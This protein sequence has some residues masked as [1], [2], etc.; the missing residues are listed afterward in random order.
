MCGIAGFWSRENSASRVDARL[1]IASMRD[2]LRHRGPDDSG[3][4][5]DA[6][7][8]I[9]LGHTRLSIVDLSPNGHQ[10]MHSRCGRFCIVYNGEVYNHAALRQQ[11][12]KCGHVFRGHSDTEVLLAGIVE[13]GLR[14]TVERCI[15][16]FAFA[17]W[18]QHEQQLTLVRDRLGIKPLYYGH[19]G[20]TLFFA[21]ELKALRAHPE[22]QGEIDRN[23][24]ALYLR[25]NYVP[26]PYSI[27]RGIFKLPPGTLLTAGVNRALDTPPVAWWSAR[28]VVERGQKTPFAGSF[29]DAV[30]ELDALL[31]DAVRLRMLSDVPLGAFL[32]GGIDSSLIVALMQKQSD[33][34]VQTFTIGFDDPQYN[35]APFAMGVARHLHTDHC[36]LYVSARQARD[37]IPRLPALYDEPFGDSSQIPTF[38]VS[39]LARRA[40][41]V[42]LS[43]DGG[44][45]LFG[46]YNR[47]FHIGNIWRRMSAVPYPLRRGAA[48][49]LRA[50]AACLPG[51]RR[52]RG[53]HARLVHRA[54]LLAIPDAGHLYGLV[55]THWPPSQEIV[56]GGAPARAPDFE[57]AAWPPLPSDFEQWMY[58]DL[59][60]YLPSDILVKVDRASMAVGLEAR[61]PL[62]D[63]RVVEFAWTLP[64][65][66]KVRGGQ[67]KRILRELL[68]RYVPSELFERPKVGFGV[69]IDAWLRGPLRDWAETLLSP[70]RLESEG[71]FHAAPIRQKWAEHLSG[72]RNWQYH[73]W[74]VLMFQSWFEACTARSEGRLNGG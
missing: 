71:F 30:N 38:L 72:R 46:G 32:S 50:I 24:L 43:G 51:S 64:H 55:N 25:H 45:E 74:D 3:Q 58:A 40:V 48:G 53:L 47:Y 67:G 31:S 63:H 23:V 66:F 42:S 41:T 37:V 39:E 56:Q 13:W 69:P 15:G 52:N 61:V 18:D 1:V 73:L 70:E 36:E 35:E 60:T 29:N 20:G 14:P 5:L 10:P 8:G 65:A 49:T 12:Q 33:R 27:Y 2:R 16:M 9:A 28:E 17:V 11:L 7:R 59:V 26:E 34:R 6:E 57:P 4:W 54:D 44:D 68:R 21:S 22:F 19:A 62:I